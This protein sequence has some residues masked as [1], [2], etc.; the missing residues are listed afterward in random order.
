[1]ITEAIFLSSYLHLCQKLIFTQFRTRLR[2]F[3]YARIGIF[4]NTWLANW[5]TLRVDIVAQTSNRSCLWKD[6]TY[7]K[8]LRMVGPKQ[9][10]KAEEIHRQTQM[11]LWPTG[12]TLQ[13]L[14]K[15]KTFC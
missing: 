2:K 11:T 5:L 1:M 10:R 6:I 12:V 7:G 13:N 9:R 4:T 3:C 15:N 14:K 8:M